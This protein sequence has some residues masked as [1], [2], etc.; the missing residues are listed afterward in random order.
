MD[1]QPEGLP[2][3][4]K[5]CTSW[6]TTQSEAYVAGPP[7]PMYGQLTVVFAGTGV[8]HGAVCTLGLMSTS[9]DLDESVMEPLAAAVKVLHQSLSTAAVTCVEIELKRGPE[10]SGPTWLYRVAE[11]GGQSGESVPPNVALLVRKQLPNLSARFSGRMFW[12]GQPET[13]VNG[14]GEVSVLALGNY[15]NALDDFMEALHSAELDPVVFGTGPGV[16]PV[17]TVSTFVPQAV[18]ATRRLRLRR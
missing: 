17:T 1:Q 15:G 13:Q 2:S 6:P 10:A 9:G 16:D 11:A 5:L 7:S 14:S 4:A 3:I 12:P 18:V 8:P